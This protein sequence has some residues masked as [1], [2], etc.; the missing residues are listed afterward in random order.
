ME[1]EFK[2]IIA[3]DSFKGSASTIQV[4]DYIEQGILR[5]NRKVEIVKVPVADGGEGTVDALVIGC[6]GEYRYA[7]VTGPMGEKVKAKF[8]IIKD[9]IAVKEILIGVGGQRHQ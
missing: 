5:L 3:A 9:N 4:E 2:I 7:D 1:K 6:K 8:G